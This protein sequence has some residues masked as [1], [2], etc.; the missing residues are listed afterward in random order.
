M[1]LGAKPQAE[2]SDFLLTKG[3]GFIIL[4]KYPDGFHGICQGLLLTA[5][6]INGKIL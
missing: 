1:K 6:I 3:D 5:G 2:C 4:M